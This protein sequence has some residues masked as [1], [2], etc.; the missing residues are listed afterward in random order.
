MA[1]H[2]GRHSARR[3]TALGSVAV[4]VV[5]A[6]SGFL[7]V[8]NLRVNRTA[9][10]ASPDT[11]GLIEQRVAEVQRLQ[12]EVNELSSQ[13]SLL[14]DVAAPSS[15]TSSPTTEDAG[16]GTTLPAIAGSGVEVTLDDSPL[17][18]QAV[19]ASGSSD[20]IDK[21]V[22]HQQDIEGVVNA[23]WAG[24]AQAVRFEDQ[25]LLF[26]S[27]VL[28][29]G[30][31]VSL[32]GKRYSPPFHITAIGD[33]GALVA[34]L[35]AS[36]SVGIYRQYVAAYGLGWK[37]ERRRNLEFPETAALL[38]PLKYAHVVPGSDGDDAQ[39]D[40]AG[41]SAAGQQDQDGGDR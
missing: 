17:W 3:G 32:H 31:V 40:D 9:Q 35:D 22:V 33:P 16:S 4:L 18:E 39:G 7:L 41:A 19:D 30:N 34:A 2:T 27:A 6:L 5:V 1:R 10:V 36:D 20:D 23:L 21:Y 28:C 11:A 13:V 24:G 8:T 14:T 26:N 37:V 25:R 38:Q 15:S 12:D 29:S